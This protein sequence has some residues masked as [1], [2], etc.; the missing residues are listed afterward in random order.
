MLK[1][2][3]LGNA[4]QIKVTGTGNALD[5]ETVTNTGGIEVVGA[6]TIDQISSIANGGGTITVD[7]T[8]TLTLNGASITGGTLGG[9]GT[10]E[11]FGAGSEST[12]DGVTIDT[13]TLVTASDNTTL[14]LTHAIANNGEIDAASG[15]TIDLATATIT[16]GTLGGPAPLTSSARARSMAAPA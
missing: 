5:N 6:L 14:D 10:I 15:G 12:L 11:T 4:G 7:S 8:G 1:N 2:G 16:G 9:T 13:G 3:T